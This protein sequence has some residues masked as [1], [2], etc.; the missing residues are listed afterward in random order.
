MYQRIIL[1]SDGS[2]LARLAFPHARAIAAATGAT[3]LLL[4]VTD[5]VDELL[6]E[7]RPTGWLDLGGDLSQD[8]A[9]D[10]A[11]QQRALAETHLAA[12]REELPGIASE[13]H[14]VAGSAGPAI[15]EAARTLD[16]DLIVMATHGR[17]GV[18]RA[19]LGSVADH[20]ARHAAC[21]VLLVR[22]S[23]GRSS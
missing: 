2:L 21:P 6:A 16:A 14:V 5:T 15:V 22:P 13:L 12:L 3:I 9:T 18:A 11:E 8:R 10:A 23:E 7:G 1:T 20:V 19:I 4:A 17:S